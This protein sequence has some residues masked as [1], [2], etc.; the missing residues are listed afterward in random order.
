MAQGKKAVAQIDEVKT[1]IRRGQERGKLSY[2]EI[3][4]TLQSVDLPPDQ[5]DSIYEMFGELGIELIGEQAA[6]EDQEPEADEVEAEE[7]EDAGR[8]L[9]VPDGV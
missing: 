5:I 9:S 3:V 6:E 7:A 1:L 4:D 8:E 2:G